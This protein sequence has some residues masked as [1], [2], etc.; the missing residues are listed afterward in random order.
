MIL[1]ALKE[2]YDRKAADPESG[3]APPGFEWKEI[4]FVIVLNE[5]GVPIAISD[6]TEVVG[7]KKRA[8]KFLVPQSVKRSVGI[9]ANFLWDNPE[10]ALGVVLK[11]N[12]ERVSRMHQTFQERIQAIGPSP[13]LGICALRKFMKGDYLSIL[14]MQFPGDWA[15]LCESGAYVTFQLAGCEGL[16]AESAPVRDHVE[17]ALIG[18][19]SETGLCLVSGDV[20]VIER[21]HPSIK[22]VWGAQSS[23][24]NIVSFNR[25]AFLSHGKEQG[26]NAPVGKVAVFAYTTALNHL[27]GKDS[28]QRVQVGDASTVFWSDRETTMEE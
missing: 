24:A 7:K 10:Y 26:A 21:L 3:I 6:T 17:T 25:G 19:G 23:G 15:K 5:D 11:G 20:D 9:A 18:D 14:E 16:I 2:F 13:D 4:P 8:K 27:L 12:A 1:Q 22:G 28:H